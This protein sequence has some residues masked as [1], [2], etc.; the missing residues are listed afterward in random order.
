MISIFGKRREKETE[1][2]DLSP[3]A[4][5]KEVADILDELEEVGEAQDVEPEEEPTE[6]EKS[7]VMTCSG[8]KAEIPVPV[9]RQNL[10]VC[11]KCGKHLPVS[12]QRRVRSLTDPGTFRK[13][14]YRVP[15]VNPLDYPEYEEKISKLQA[16]TGLDEGVLAG[17]GEIDGRR[18]LICV[19]GSEFLMGSMGIAVGEKITNAFEVADKCKLPIIVFTASGGARMQEGILS[20]MQMAKTSAAVEKFSEHGG[21]YI[22]CL[23]HP[24]TGGV[25]ASFAM[26]ADITLAEPGALIGFAGPRVIEQTIGQTLPEGFQRAE[27]LEQHGYVDQIVER[28][29]MKQVISQ[30]LKLHDRKR[31]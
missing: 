22:S 5:G 23:T 17:I 26:L 18:A 10:Y 25:S 24:T 15:F 31:R 11:P 13:L 30:I 28:S 12:A 1:A 8:C 19:M 21:L 29:E 7:A 27:Y 9:M 14:K 4:A 16:K 20:L 3:E 6:E 2:K